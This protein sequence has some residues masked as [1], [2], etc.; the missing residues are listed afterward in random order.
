M[1][2]CKAFAKKGKCSQL[3]YLQAQYG[4]SFNLMVALG[5]STFVC[6]IVSSWYFGSSRTGCFTPFPKELDPAAEYG[7]RASA[8]VLPGPS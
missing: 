4:S 2:Q 6:G 5:V 1:C 3:F 8:Y 7:G